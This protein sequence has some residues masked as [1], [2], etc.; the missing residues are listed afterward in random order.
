MRSISTIISGT[1]K[2]FFF[3]VIRVVCIEKLFC[4][5]T[6]LGIAEVCRFLFLFMH[7]PMQMAFCS[8]HWALLIRLYPICPCKKVIILIRTGKRL[9]KQLAR[10]PSNFFYIPFQPVLSFKRICRILFAIRFAYISTQK[11]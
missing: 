4:P 9:T 10:L 11:F 3:L 8:R 7:A 2:N 6:R 1:T 5:S